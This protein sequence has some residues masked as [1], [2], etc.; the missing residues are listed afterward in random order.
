MSVRVIAFFFFFVVVRRTNAKQTRKVFNFSCG[1]DTFRLNAF[2]VDYK[3]VHTI[4][5]ARQCDE[6]LISSLDKTVFFVVVVLAIGLVNARM[7]RGQLL[8]RLIF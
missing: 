3:C 2:D 4:A 8:W 1:N 6:S 7:C 5:A